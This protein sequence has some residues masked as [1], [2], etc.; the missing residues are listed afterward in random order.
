MTW[1]P[2]TW[3]TAHVRRTEGGIAVARGASGEDLLFLFSLSSCLGPGRDAL[4]GLAEAQC[5]QAK[6]EVVGF[7]RL[8]WNRSFLGQALAGSTA[9]TVLGLSIGDLSMSVDEEEC[10]LAVP[11]VGIPCFF[12]CERMGMPAEAITMMTSGENVQRN[13]WRVYVRAWPL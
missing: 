8:A 4:Q 3:K 12:R 7:Q 5:E 2:E 10:I 11:F 9:Y 6:R 13:T 1:N